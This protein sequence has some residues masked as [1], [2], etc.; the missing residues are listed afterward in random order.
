MAGRARLF[1]AL[2]PD[3]VVRSNIAEA[4]ANLEL[5]GRVTAANKLHVTLVFLGE[6]DP[7]R[8]SCIE[9]GLAS[10]EAS[11]FEFVL[12]QPVW[13]RRSAMVW[14]TASA[15]PAS[16]RD[17]V[18]Q[19]RAALVSCGHSPDPRPYRLHLTAARNVH[20]FTHGRVFA[21]ISWRVSDFCLVSSTLS[22]SGSEYSIV[23]RWPLS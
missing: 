9:Q 3:A 13:R 11:P 22:A 7:T 17:L 14:L 18:T 16:L 19:L 20:R 5:R 21:P 23:K 6:I 12:S 8:R 10:I 4:I 15:V 2:W 1:I